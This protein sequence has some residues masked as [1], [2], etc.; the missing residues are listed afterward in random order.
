MA[1]LPSG[2]LTFL[3]TDLEGSS[4]LW[5]EHPDAMRTAVARHDALL[6]DTVTAHA[7][8]VVKGTGDGMYAAFASPSDALAAAVAAQHGIAAE[9]WPDIPLRAR[10]G[11][12]SGEAE[13]R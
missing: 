8:A 2:T 7:G 4:R 13:L 12:H 6:R 11:L 9:S 10:I 5:D 3:F 1:E